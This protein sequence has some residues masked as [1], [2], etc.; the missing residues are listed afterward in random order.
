[1][2]VCVCVDVVNPSMLVLVERLLAAESKGQLLSVELSRVLGHFKDL[3]KTHNIT[4]NH[5]YFRM[6]CN[7]N[8]WLINSAMQLEMPDYGPFPVFLSLSLLSLFQSLSLDRLIDR[9]FMAFLEGL[10]SCCLWSF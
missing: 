8:V 5:T 3:N 9:L 10:W 6:L 2:C 4:G 1:M 7:I